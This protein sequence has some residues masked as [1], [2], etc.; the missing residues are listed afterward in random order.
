MRKKQQHDLTQP[1]IDQVIEEAMRREQTI[2]EY[3]RFALESVG[4]D[5]KETLSRLY[6][7]EDGRI[8]TLRLLLSEIRELRE[9]STPMVG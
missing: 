1:D 2:Q 7:E 6:L 9:L 8:E 5:A 3:Y 4:P